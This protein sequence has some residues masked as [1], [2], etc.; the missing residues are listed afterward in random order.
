MVASA[1]FRMALG[2]GGV[3]VGICRA[4]EVKGLDQPAPQPCDEIFGQE[5]S[6]QEIPAEEEQ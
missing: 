6:T 5:A 4:E 1:L 2:K 3:E